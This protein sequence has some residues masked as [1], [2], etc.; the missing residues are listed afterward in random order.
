MLAARLAAR[1]AAKLAARLAARKMAARWAARYAS[2]LLDR[3]CGREVDC[4]VCGCEY[5]LDVAASMG[6]LVRC[7]L[8]TSCVAARLIAEYVAASMG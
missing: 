4:R 7:H 8:W 5:G 3:L 6:N 1:L 2:A